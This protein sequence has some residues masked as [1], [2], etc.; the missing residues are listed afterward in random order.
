MALLTHSLAVVLTGMALVA[1]GTF[2]AQ[3]IATGHVSRT[4]ATGKATASG[5]YLA[6]YYSG[7]LVGSV[8]LGQVFDGLGWP[9]CIAVLVAVLLIAMLLARV[10]G[11]DADLSRAKAATADPTGTRP[12]RLAPDHTRES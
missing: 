11:R 10:L 7:G 6:S 1:V 12:N 8:V 4:A 5:I 3:A 9:A 2:L